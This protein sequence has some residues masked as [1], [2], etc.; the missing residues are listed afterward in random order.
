MT[1][2]FKKCICKAAKLLVLT[3]PVL[4]PEKFKENVD[5]SP[6]LEEYKEDLINRDV[7]DQELPL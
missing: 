1:H 5:I 7:E 2:C 6:I 4:C 3:P